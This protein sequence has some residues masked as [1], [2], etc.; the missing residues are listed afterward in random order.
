MSNTIPQKLID[1]LKNL[2]ELWSEAY[3][4][5]DK[6]SALQEVVAIYSHVDLWRMYEAYARTVKSG[7]IEP[8]LAQKEFSL[9]LAHEMADESSDQRERIRA[10]VQKRF[11]EINDILWFAESS[12]TFKGLELKIPKN[13]PES[14]TKEEEPEAVAGKKPSKLSKKKLLAIAAIEKAFKKLEEPG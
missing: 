1:S 8:S 9:D 2:A 13:A 5:L 14:M 4:W 6:Q 10:K 12:I 3:P 11:L 7:F